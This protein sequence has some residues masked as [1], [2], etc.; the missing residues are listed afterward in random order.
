MFLTVYFFLRFTKFLSNQ[1]ED[2]N[3]LNVISNDC[4]ATASSYSGHTPYNPYFNNNNNYNAN[5]LTHEAE[6]LENSAKKN[7]KYTVRRILDAN[8][9]QFQLKS[10]DKLSRKLYYKKSLSPYINT[11]ENSVEKDSNRLYAAHYRHLSSHSPSPAP[12]MLLSTQHPLIIPSAFINIL[13]MAIENN[14]MDVLRICLKYGL[15]ANEPGTNKKTIKLKNNNNNNSQ[16][17]ASNTITKTNFKCKY[18]FKKNEFFNQLTHTKLIEALKTDENDF[19][20]EKELLNLNIDKEIYKNQQYLICLPPLF[21]TISR[22]QH[23]ATEL[24]LEYGACPNIQDLYGNTP[25]HI[26]CAKNKSCELCINLLIKYHASSLV[27]N[28]IQQTPESILDSL[29]SSISMQKLRCKLIDDIFTSNLNFNSLSNTGGYPHKLY[30]SSASNSLNYGNGQLS[31]TN[32]TKS[33]VSSS[34]N[35]LTNTIM[36]SS[37]IRNLFAKKHKSVST[38]DVNSAMPISSSNYLNNNNNNNNNKILARITSRQQSSSSEVTNTLPKSQQKHSINISN[39]II[40]KISSINKLLSVVSI[41]GGKSNNNGSSSSSTSTSDGKLKLTLKKSL[42]SQ[43]AACNKSLINIPPTIV[44]QNQI[45]ADE[46]Q[47]QH[48]MNSPVSSGSGNN[49]RKSINKSIYSSTNYQSTRIDSRNISNDTD[50]KN[51]TISLV[52]SKLSLLKKFVSLDR[53]LD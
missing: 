8:Y 6:L 49:A 29:K 17:P 21:L 51:D 31:I 47:Q 2:N 40:N 24:L 26:A 46:Q 45:I 3:Y 43:S 4:L 5:D 39:P 41:G 27:Q 53:I 22:C 52:S 12:A 33:I 34:R 10:I 30:N 23:S 50:T 20:V 14:A 32:C 7:D 9:S 19:D 42:S 48:P 37:S 28:N 36:S 13:H 15:N 11:R 1:S 38:F 25:L 16:Q 35:S 44:S 18:C